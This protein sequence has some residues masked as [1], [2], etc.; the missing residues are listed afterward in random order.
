MSSKGFNALDLFG[1]LHRHAHIHTRTQF[2]IFC[3]HVSLGVHATVWLGRSEDSI[4][5]LVFLHCV[6]PEDRTSV[7][8]L[9]WQALLLAAPPNLVWL[10]W[11][12][13]G[14]RGEAILS[15]GSTPDILKE[16]GS[17]DPS[18]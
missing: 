1:H 7:L 3:V 11:G 13:G 15:P 9:A 17:S 18:V 8:R 4:Q 12:R 14:G 16:K 6:S 5:E 10:L 2:K